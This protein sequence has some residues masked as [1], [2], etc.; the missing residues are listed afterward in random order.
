[1]PLTTA[2]A[3]AERV[4]AG[5]LG[6]T[7]VL[8]LIGLSIGLP[9]SWLATRAIRGLLYDVGVSDPVTYAVVPAMLAGVAALA[10]FLPARR[11]TRIDPAIALRSC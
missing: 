2:G 7:A 3:T 10:G 6:E 1:V 5:V 4:R 9:L 8:A 11:A